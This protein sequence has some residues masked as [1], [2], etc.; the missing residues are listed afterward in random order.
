MLFSE[1]I[2]VRAI[3]LAVISDCVI[4]VILSIWYE[5]SP[6]L[7]EWILTRSRHQWDLTRD[8]TW[9]STTVNQL[10]E[11][12]SLFDGYNPPGES[13]VL[14]VELTLVDEA[15]HLLWRQW[16]IT[17][18]Q[19]DVHQ[20]QV[21]SPIVT[22]YCLENPYCVVTV[23]PLAFLSI[24][25]NKCCVGTQC[26]LKQFRNKRTFFNTFVSEKWR[27]KMVSILG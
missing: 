11:L 12:F 7:M 21:I 25:I 13:H 27:T 2:F 26:V 3:L 18:K 10:S 9:N 8:L 20:Q 23:M 14:P 17:A 1:D 24:N 6:S 22:S 5:I 15:I 16:G 19:L 4:A